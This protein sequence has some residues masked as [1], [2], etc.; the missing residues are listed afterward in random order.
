M[1]EKSREKL[2]GPFNRRQ[3]KRSIHSHR[4]AQFRSSVL[5][6]SIV[7]FP[8]F[9]TKQLPPMALLADT[10]LNPAIPAV[11]AGNRSAKASQRSVAAVLDGSMRRQYAT[12]L[13]Y[14]EVEDVGWP[15]NTASIAA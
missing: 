7:R 2:L 15:L 5:A 1:R 12:L 6:L 11:R 10:K 3:F 13:R 8:G 4:T 14:R 9:R